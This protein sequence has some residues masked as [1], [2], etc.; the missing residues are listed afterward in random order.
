MLLHDVGQ[1]IEHVYFPT[2]GLVSLVTVMSDGQTLE[3]SQIGREGAIG[4]KA[5]FGLTTALTRALVQLPGAGLR[6]PTSQLQAL[7]GHCPA[8]KLAIALFNERL[9]AQIQQLAGCSALHSL[10]ARV[11]RWLLATSDRI[12][13]AEIAINQDALARSLGVHRGTLNKTLG[14]LQKSGSGLGAS[15]A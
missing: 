1:A 12:G 15:T 10:E 4:T 7:I 11:C 9:V 14:L 13:G 5:A 6:I 3:N 2:S 8:L